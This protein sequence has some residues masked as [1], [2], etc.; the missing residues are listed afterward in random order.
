MSN[1][2]TGE[3]DLVPADRP[4]ETEYERDFYSW[5]IEQ[6]RLIR[7]GRWAAVDRENVAEEIESLGREQFAKLESAI[8][9]LLDAHAQVGSSAGPSQPKLVA[10]DQSAT[11]A[12]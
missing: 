3:A 10:I 1:R 5:S 9:V 2:P 7:E 4:A 6:A 11:D 12:R 8:H